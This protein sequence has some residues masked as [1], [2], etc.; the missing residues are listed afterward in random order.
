[1]ARDELRKT[2]AG[3]GLSELEECAVLVLSELL[4]NAVEHGCGEGAGVETRYVSRPCGLRVEVCDVSPKLPVQRESEPGEVSGRGL[5]IVEALS[6]QW[7]WWYRRGHGKTVWAE[8]SLPP[9]PE[10][11]L[12]HGG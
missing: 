12:H 5:G 6:D 7:G 3:W 8:L 9:G 10:G 2:L 11:G 1:M 4:T